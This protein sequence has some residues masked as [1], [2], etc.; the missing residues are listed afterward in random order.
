MARSTFYYNLRNRKKEGKYKEE[1]A[2][3]YTIFHKHKGRYVY[4]RVTLGLRNSGR[5][6]HH[7]HVKKLMEE[8]DL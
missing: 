3:I 1:K 7:A 5:L 2:M 6:I 8:M 4:G